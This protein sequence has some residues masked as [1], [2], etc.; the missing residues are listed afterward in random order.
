[1]LKLLFNQSGGGGNMTVTLFCSYRNLK[2]PFS[3]I[4]FDR[5]FKSA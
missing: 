4:L 2:T 5:Y 3:A 1:M